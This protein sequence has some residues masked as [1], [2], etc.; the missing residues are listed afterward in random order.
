MSKDYST[1]NKDELAA[2][3]KR[4]K[5]EVE[6]LEDTFQFNLANTSAH[7]SSGAVAEHEEEI[8]ELKEL[9]A[10]VESLLAG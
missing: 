3:L 9:I 7:L 8:A 1:M 4:L 6:D 2:E 10:K 5:N